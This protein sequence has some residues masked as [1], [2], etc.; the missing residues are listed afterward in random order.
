MVNTP[1]KTDAKT[2]TPK[3]S[4]RP[5]APEGSQQ[6]GPKADSPG[7]ADNWVA[8]HFP[9]QVGSVSR[10]AGNSEDLASHA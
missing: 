10:S 8:A 1:N 5:V 7:Q 2:L 4:D 9:L 6:P 3:G